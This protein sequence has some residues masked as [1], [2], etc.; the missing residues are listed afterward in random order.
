MKKGKTCWEI[1]SITTTIT[2]YCI[3]YTFCP[4]LLCAEHFPLDF[5]VC[6]FSC[7]SSFLFLLFSPFHL[8]LLHVS[9]GTPFTRVPLTSSRIPAMGV[10]VLRF[11]PK[12]VSPVGL[13]GLHV[14][15]SV[16]SA[17]VW[18][19]H[20]LRLACSPTGGTFLTKVGVKTS[21]NSVSPNLV[22]PEFR[23]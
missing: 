1:V 23:R 10:K 3:Y 12:F 11:R 6:P 22:I 16:Q 2:S 14:L 8:P 13:V 5:W 18:R 17:E 19:L 7:F 15:F 4:F 20:V 21:E 9:K